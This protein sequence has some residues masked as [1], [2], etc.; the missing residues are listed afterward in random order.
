MSQGASFQYAA[1]AYRSSSVTQPPL[2]QIILLYDRVIQELNATV[3]E[4]ENCHPEAAFNRLNA[5]ITILRGLLHSLNFEKGGKVAELLHASYL[6]L[7]MSALAAFGKQDA[8]DRYRRLIVGIVD[9]RN[10]WVV[11]QQWQNRH[12]R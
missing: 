9:L 11:V 6:R 5:A 8:V 12:P 1:A 10:G 4:I 2:A 3:G 7:I